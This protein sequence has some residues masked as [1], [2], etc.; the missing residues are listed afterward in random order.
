MQ[1]LETL[2]EGGPTGAVSSVGERLV[3]TQVAGGSN[4]SP[5]MEMMSMQAS[6][7]N[8]LMV[9]GQAVILRERDRLPRSSTLP[10]AAML[11]CLILLVTTLACRKQV[12][13]SRTE[14]A[15]S[16]APESLPPPSAEAA[17]TKRA[18][19]TS[20]P[21]VA[22]T[23]EDQNPAK[24]AEQAR[25][26][27]AQL[28]TSLKHAL[29]MSLPKGLHGA[30]AAC[31]LKA[32]KVAAAASAHTGIELGRT[33]SRVRNPDNAAA[34]WTKEMLAQ[35]EAD[36]RGKWPQFRTV[37]LPGDK[38]GYAE[39]IVVGPLC[40]NCHGKQLAPSVAKVLDEKY[41]DDKARGYEEGDLRGIFWA[42]VR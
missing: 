23:S 12:E 21:K 6:R 26:A 30:I 37:K 14:N 5:P 40:L 35:Y 11:V 3:Y 17:S 8:T 33:S 1:E 9:E 2:A 15:S 31:Q 20:K 36:S 7:K 28:K 16:A 42:V 38:L 41:P 22:A 4:P 32:P 27:L 34:G 13:T 24:R 10:C 25:A 39:P 29:K 18:A 19:P